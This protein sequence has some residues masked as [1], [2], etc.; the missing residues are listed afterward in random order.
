MN[1]LIDLAIK[2]L[3]K[4]LAIPLALQIMILCGIPYIGDLYSSAPLDLQKL[5][6]TIPIL[7][8][9][10]ILAL[11][12]LLWLASYIVLSN[13]IKEELK[14]QFGAFW[15]HHREPHCPNCKALLQKF[16]AQ[17]VVVGLNCIKCDRMI[18]LVTDD[19]KKLTYPEAKR[20]L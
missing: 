19:G 6:E 11:S 3:S 20:M 18:D 2:W 12:Y 16:S 17:S 15:D 1:K 7:T 5:N 13:K 4:P 9:A 8:I 10:T 14:P